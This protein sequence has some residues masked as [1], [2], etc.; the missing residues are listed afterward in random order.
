MYEPET[1]PTK[2]NLLDTQ[3][4]LAFAR[5]G[6]ALLDQKRMVLIRELNLLNEKIILFRAETEK[7]RIKADAALQHAHMEMGMDAFALAL[8]TMKEI[9]DLSLTTAS[10][11]EAV[12]CLNALKQTQAALTEMLNAYSRLT[13]QIN[14]TNKR[15]NA[16]DNI[17]IPRLEGNVKYITDSLDERERDEFIRMKMVKKINL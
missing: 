1:A 3:S 16:L 4:R 11:D 5:K 14:K 15:A 8:R 7:K 10:F 13:G 12:F 9:P 2:G 6:F 17:V